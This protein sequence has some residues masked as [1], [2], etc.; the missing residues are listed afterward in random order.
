MAQVAAFQVVLQRIGFTADAIASL[1]ANGIT[2][3]D[4]L[5]NLSEKDIEQIMKIIRT[6]PPAVAVSYLA[7]K[8]LKTFSFWVTRRRR[9]DEPIQAHLFTNQVLKAYTV[10]MT[11]DGKDEDTAVK[12]PGEFKKDTKWKSFKEGM[13]AYLNALKGKH[14]IP[15]AYVIREDAAPQVNV[16]YQSEHH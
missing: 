1:T 6:G 8:R 13:I 11:L 7:Q 2:T 9:L 5:I 12:S 10:M 16:A 3:T 15:L 4:D 14:N